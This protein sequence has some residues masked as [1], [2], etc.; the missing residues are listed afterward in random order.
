MAGHYVARLRRPPTEFGK[1]VGCGSPPSGTLAVRAGR[2]GITR[3]LRRFA[4]ASPETELRLP[5]CSTCREVMGKSDIASEGL[6]LLPLGAVALAL[7]GG[8]AGTDA[9][10]A[11]GGLA[12]Q[13][14]G[15]AVGVGHTLFRWPRVVWWSV[16][17][18]LVLVVPDKAVAEALEQ[19]ASH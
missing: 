15:L 7:L 17:G 10:V 4:A 14:S 11:L 2:W 3:F 19:A 16:A 8:L 6:W 12:G 9:G 5:F 18:G 13:V 1:C